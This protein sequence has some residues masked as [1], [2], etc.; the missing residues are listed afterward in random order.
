MGDRCIRPYRAWD[1]V[2]QDGVDAAVGGAVIPAPVAIVAAVVEGT[3]KGKGKGTLLPSRVAASGAA[4]AIL[5]DTRGAVWPVVR[6]RRR[7]LGGAERHGRRLLGGT[8]RLDRRACELEEGAPGHL[9]VELGAD[10]PLAVL[11]VELVVAVER[12][13]A[14]VHDAARGALALLEAVVRVEVVADLVRHR[15]PRRVVGV[16]VHARVVARAA[17]RAHVGDADGAGLAAVAHQVPQALRRLV[18][19]PAGELVELRLDVRAAVAASGVP[20]RSVVR[21]GRQ[22]DA[23]QPED[24][25]QLRLVDDVRVVDDLGQVGQRGVAAAAHDVVQRGAHGD[26]DVQRVVASVARV[27]VGPRLHLQPPVGVRFVFFVLR[28]RVLIMEVLMLVLVV[29]LSVALAESSLRRT[30][31]TVAMRRVLQVGHHF[32]GVVLLVG[33]HGLSVLEDHHHVQL[34]AGHGHGGLL[35]RAEAGSVQGHHV[36]EVAQGDLLL[37]VRGGDGERA[38]GLQHRRREVQV[39]DLVRVVEVELHREVPRGPGLLAEPPRPCQALQD[40]G[41]VA[42]HDDEVGQEHPSRVGLGGLRDRLDV[43]G[44]ERAGQEGQ[45]RQELRQHGRGDGSEIWAVAP[46][47]KDLWRLFGHRNWRKS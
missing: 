23:A 28:V 32:V 18:G 9:L 40:I 11:G 4:D 34:L 36:Q 17:Q 20:G 33:H 47:E 15:D 2:V 22:V 6:R 7:L 30:H 5:E 25:V 39:H 29:L 19:R 16:V 13:V 45:K 14:V 31:A 12:A 44:A 37:A 38:R 27:A 43:R 1:V 24:D 10:L 21:A 35:A 3:G 42:V 46:V 26:A 41:S 8:W